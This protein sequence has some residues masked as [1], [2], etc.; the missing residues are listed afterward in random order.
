[1][2]KFQ[3]GITTDQ[4]GRII[5]FGDSTKNDPNPAPT[6]SKVEQPTP[7][8][9]PITAVPF[10]PAIP[11]ATT[12]MSSDAAEARR[13]ADEEYVAQ[14]QAQDKQMAD[15]AEILNKANVAAVEADYAKKEEEARNTYASNEASKGVEQF[16]L[17]TRDTP[18]GS[19]ERADLANKKSNYFSALTAE[20]QSKIAQLTQAY[21]DNDYKRINAL[22]DTIKQ[23]QT[24]QETFLQ[25]ERT[26]QINE[27]KTIADTK[28]AQDKANLDKVKEL[29]PTLFSSLGDDSVKNMATIADFAK[30][31][32]LDPNSVAASV[33]TYQSDKQKADLL[34]SSDV[35]NILAKTAGGGE[36][37]VPGLGKIK[38][39]GTSVDKAPTTLTVGNKVYNWSGGEWTDTGLAADALSPQNVLDALKTIGTSSGDMSI[40]SNYLKKL[41][42]DV[43]A[44]SGGA[45]SIEDFK[46]AI[47]NQESGNY[48]AVNKDSGALGAYQIMPYHLAQIGLN[49][50]DAADRQKY[51]DTPA[52]QDQL[53]NKM[54]DASSATYG[55]DTRKMAA[56]YYGGAGGAQALDTADG[57]QIGKYDKNGALTGYPSINEYV[58]SV[59]SK[60]GG[61]NGPTPEEITFLS[62]K[63]EM[64]KTAYNKL[65]PDDRSNVRQ[66]ISGDILINSVAAGMGGAATRQRLLAAAKLIEPEFSET[67]NEQRVKFKT[68]WN[69]PSSNQFKTTTAINTGLGHLAEFAEKAKLLDNTQ[70]KSYNT[71]VNYLKNE[72]GTAAI[73][74]FNTV[75]TALSSELAAIYKN[76]TAPTD[77]ETEEWRKTLLSSLSSEQMTGA[78][79]T[80]SKLISSKL[81]SLAEEYKKTMGEYPHDS[82]VNAD[83][84]IKL[85]EAG[86]DISAVEDTIAKQSNQLLVEDIKTGQKGYI[87][88]NE[89]DDKLYKKI[90]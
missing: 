67:K 8:I 48:K 83:V 22:R 15:S 80:A 62:D 12:T 17:G 30:Q 29:T 90:Q 40:L 25:K 44:V 63:T 47:T 36:V 78:A 21:Q 45:V 14:I 46:K 85:K 1:M 54:I 53:F 75:V 31:Y 34:N 81:A 84:I 65:K 66:L 32:G 56:A 18:Y 57:D 73:N 69:S 13:K 87:P 61:S 68:T 3:D 50:D 4:T 82:I 11:I 38:I 70:L 72:T 42:I 77:Q 55:G 76:G 35:A 43:P 49:G 2:H 33:I 39:V 6:M 7:F 16:K 23:T 5:G 64:Q 79:T 59:I 28:L 58:N 37:D 60:A 20:K 89:F 19:A 86:V 88:T 51:L 52:L 10:A 9:T 74:N 71:L 24:D 27:Y 26:N 41:G